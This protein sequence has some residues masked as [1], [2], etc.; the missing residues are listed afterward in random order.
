MDSISTDASTPTERQP[1]FVKYWSAR[2]VPHAMSRCVLSAV[3]YF[4][5]CSS[6]IVRTALKKRLPSAWSYAYANA[7]YA[8]PR[9]VTRAL[10]G[11][12]ICVPKVEAFAA[13]LPELSVRHHLAQDPWRLEA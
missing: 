8:S 1:R 9:D 5:S 6:S 10:A 11:R 2:P 12:S 4:A 7:A 13:L 3:G